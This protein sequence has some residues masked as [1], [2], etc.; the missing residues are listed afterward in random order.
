MI[1]LYSDGAETS[2]S[3]CTTDEIR[4][5][6]SKKIISISDR[7]GKTIQSCDDQASYSYCEL[8]DGLQ[9]SD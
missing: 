8:I 7:D 2:L 5:F 6:S 9:Q 1:L 4:E 3:Q